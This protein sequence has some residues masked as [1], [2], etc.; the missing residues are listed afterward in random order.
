MNTSCVTRAGGPNAP[1]PPVHTPRRHPGRRGC[2]QRRSGQPPGGLGPQR[3][4]PS[5]PTRMRKLQERFSGSQWLSTTS[6]THWSVL[7]STT[8]RSSR[9]SWSARVWYQ[10]RV[11]SSRTGGGRSVEVWVLPLSRRTFGVSQ[12]GTPRFDVGRGKRPEQDALI[13]QLRLG[14]EDRRAHGRQGMRR[15]AVTSVGELQGC[16]CPRSRRAMGRAAVP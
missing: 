16:R 12:H 9:S 10:V 1:Q 8:A 2:G 3:S 5:A 13:S 4:R 15:G 11:R 7:A 6:P 14:I